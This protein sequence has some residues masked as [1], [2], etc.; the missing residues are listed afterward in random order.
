[1]RNERGGIVGPLNRL[2]N[3]L[4]AKLRNY[5]LL[6]YPLETPVMI[7]QRKRKKLWG[8]ISESFGPVPVAHGADLAELDLADMIRSHGREL[9]RKSFIFGV[10]P[11][12]F[13]SYALLLIRRLA[14]FVDYVYTDTRLGSSHFLRP[15]RSVQGKCADEIL[16]ELVGELSS[17]YATS[18]SKPAFPSR[19]MV[20]D[21]G[22]P[23][24]DF[25]QFQIAKLRKASKNERKQEA[26]KLQTWA[27]FL[28]KLTAK[29][30]PKL[31][32]QDAGHLHDIVRKKARW[33][34]IRYHRLITDGLPQ[35]YSTESIIMRG[36]RFLQPGEEFLLVGESRV[37]TA[38]GPGRI[39]LGLFV[40]TVIANPKR[41]GQLAVMKPV[42][43]FDIKTRT[44]FNWEIQTKKPKGKRKKTVARFIVRKRGMTD[45]E[46]NDALAEVPEEND[47]QQLSLYADGLV[48]EYSRLTGDESIS[49]ILRG[50]VLLDS[51]FDAGL[52][53]TV[54]RS[55][56]RGL[57]DEYQSKNSL[58]VCDRLLIRSKDAIA[59][60]AALVLHSPTDNQ[61]IGLGSERNRQEIED[62]Y[63]PFSEVRITTARHILY[64]SARSA[65]NSGF[66]AGW[67]AQY[68]HGLRYLLRLSTEDSGAPVTWLDLSGEFGHD[69]L[70]K[71]R[72]R[73]SFQNKDLQD[74]FDRIRI[75]DMSNS[76]E[77][78][79]F[80]GGNLPDITSKLTQGIVV[81]SGLQLIE[82]SLPPRLGPVLEELERFMVQEISKT[83]NVT[84]W[85]LQ[86]RPDERT[87]EKYHSRCLLPFW[88]SSEHRFRVTDIVWN[89][90]V[91]PYTSV[92]T[93]PMLDDLRVIIKQ[94]GQSVKT[95]LVEVPPLENWSSR[96]WS[97]RSIRK[98]KKKGQSG[99]P[100]RDAL[101][102][103]D[104]IKMNEFRE[105]LI[106]DSIDLIPWLCTHHP[107]RC[108][109]DNDMEAQLVIQVIPLYGAPTKPKSVMSRMVYCRRARGG[110]GM[111]A[112]VPPQKLIPKEA[113]THPR[114]YRRYR[115][116]RRRTM[117]TQTYRAPDEKRLEFRNLMEQTARNVEIRRFRQ[118]L[119]LLSSQKGSWAADGPWLDL[120]KQLG[121]LI[122]DESD[123]VEIDELYKISELL[124]T[125]ELTSELWG[126]MLWFRERR[127]NSGLRLN[128]LD[129]LDIL[130]ESRPY[131]AALYGNYLFLLLVALA[132]KY[133]DLRIDEIQALWE[134]MKSWHLRQVGFYL[135]DVLGV[136]RPKFDV[137]AV[138]SN[139]CKRASVLA[140]MPLP[141]QSAVR[142][143]QL[144]VTS[145]ED[146][147]EY[148][149][150]FEDHHDKNLLRSGLWIGLN[151]LDPSSSIRW[152]ESNI[153]EIVDCASTVEP[154][155]VYSLV[156]CEVRR[157]EYVWFLAE[158]EWNLLGELVVIPRRR[159]AVTSIRGLQIV[160]PKSTK[161]PDIP[162]GV[163]VSPD[164]HQRVEQELSEIAQM[165]HHI[166]SVQCQL[167][168]NSEMYT[169]NFESDGKQVDSREVIRTSNLLSLLR[170]PLTD[171]TPIQS[172]NNPDMYLTWNPYED[173]SYGQLQILRPYVQR[174]SPYIQAKL[175]IP[176]TC[177]EL[178][179][180]PSLDASVMLSHVEEKCP[181]AQGSS[182]EHG[183]CWKLELQGDAVPS[184][185]IAL[186]D[187]PLS[188]QDVSSL[189]AAGEVF[190]EGA[191]CSLNMQ[192]EHDPKGRDGTVFRE[193]RKIAH[194]LGLK[195][196]HQGAFLNLN[197]EKLQFSPVKDGTAIRVFVYSDMTGE[198]VSETVLFAPQAKW[199]V[200]TVL[201]RF[202]EDT[203]EFADEYFGG[204][205]DLKDRIID[206]RGLIDTMRR[207]LN[208]IHRRGQRRR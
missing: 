55:L 43:V 157:T 67:L 141:I 27:R 5:F 207:I 89:L 58:R 12:D 134:T 184:E 156:T 8:Y 114:H 15:R 117:N 38:E 77:Q 147:N 92:Q 61:F 45:D 162:V 196:V 1:M 132:R 60:R 135:R 87:S 112:Y 81:V 16:R 122:P 44:S 150:F 143:G 91:R 97:K 197:S 69:E 131:V 189:L 208:E 59:Q 120:L 86:P 94:T 47:A 186:L 56:L 159:H 30:N 65:S 125:H 118:T 85:F 64:L 116:K 191:R 126:S 105:E 3:I 33:E 145:S 130:L 170:R 155:E 152:S 190:L 194:A 149:V 107:D 148:W 70:A 57:I 11:S 158:E 142:H 185:T 9:C 80:L 18:S 32:A 138:W 173:V 201:N 192:F 176:Q 153:R 73:L 151:P 193:S 106:K 36:T 42:A 90:P 82:D 96:F 46:W 68:W 21:E 168:L 22:P 129:H 128:E 183:L 177:T 188:D 172:S 62:K 26:E 203:I 95:E 63:N 75:F 195:P 2:I 164:L 17:L 123:P 41:P 108:K 20:H 79:L 179:E 136:S 182:K 165:R 72:L 100:G 200:D 66:T 204:I 48:R 205:D 206:L 113:I 25:F 181:I 178:V 39:D 6:M 103:R 171:G 14:R 127:L 78:F 198:R 160:P 187:R 13:D 28:R 161:T 29:K 23:D 37:G 35:A 83:G 40:R 163:S 124:M 140:R 154:E 51:Q 74:F 174:G 180:L 121:R 119:S 137:R 54:V 7:G 52:N 98:S 202:R 88:D 101:S 10:P 167:G 139:L 50:V 169:V 71:K 110:S 84:L 175:P 34:G 104:V 109:K 24:A 133:S 144:L 99:T 102:A 31:R 19:A 146:G 115:R 199:D 4:G 93:A 76:I 53:R 111:R 166:T 49:D